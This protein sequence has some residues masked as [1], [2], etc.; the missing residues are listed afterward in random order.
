MLATIRFCQGVYIL[1][2]CVFHFFRMMFLGLGTCP[3]SCGDLGIIKSGLKVQGE[4]VFR[5]GGVVFRI[6]AFF[7]FF[8]A[9][10]NVVQADT[11]VKQKYV[12]YSVTS[13]SELGGFDM[14]A[15]SVMN[16]RFQGQVTDPFIFQGGLAIYS[17]DDDNVRSAY[18][19]FAG[20]GYRHAISRITDV[21]GLLSYEYITADASSGGSDNSSG[22]GLRAGV[23]HLLAPELELMAE[24][25]RID[26]GEVTGVLVEG[27]EDYVG[28]NVAVG[29]MFEDGLRIS[30][31]YDRIDDQGGFGLAFD[32]IW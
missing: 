2:W 5:S 17:Y 11:A 8:L 16:F 12:G 3:D 21:Y 32:W 30:F 13:Y 27:E 23:R 26:A 19:A 10:A 4:V 25:R 7:F 29:Y 9:A 31:A 14:N 22:H 18:S 20:L 6:V 28:F 15:L 24:A 1:P